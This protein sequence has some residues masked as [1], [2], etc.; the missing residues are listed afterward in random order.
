MRITRE[1]AEA[2][3]RGDENQNLSSHQAASFY[4]NDLVVAV[5]KLSDRIEQVKRLDMARLDAVLRAEKAEAKIVELTTNYAEQLKGF[6]A[7][8]CGECGKQKDI[9]EKAEAALAEAKRNHEAQVYSLNK[10]IHRIINE[11]DAVIAAQAKQLEA[12]D[13]FLI[14]YRTGKTPPAWAFAALATNKP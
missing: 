1:D 11:R 6:W 8:I 3:Y 12:K 14:A 13:A 4:R 2:W 9:A 7:G 5:A 10:Q